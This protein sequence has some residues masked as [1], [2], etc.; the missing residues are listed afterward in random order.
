MSE[1]FIREQIIRDKSEEDRK[2]EL[3]C[4]ILDAKK[5]LNNLN[6][7]FNVA[8]SDMIDYYVYQIKANQSKLDH[9]IRVAKANGII[10]NMENEIKYRRYIE[11]DA[12]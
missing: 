10:L 4:S 9:L 3:I 1:E 2:K 7:N 12:G 5:E 6:T 11:G 8:D